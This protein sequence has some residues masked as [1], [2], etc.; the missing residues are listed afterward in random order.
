M[1][2]M[3]SLTGN[4]DWVAK[5]TLATRQTQP[6]ARAAASRTSD[7]LG[8]RKDAECQRTTL[9][10]RFSPLLEAR[11]TRRRFAHAPSPTIANRHRATGAMPRD[12]QPSAPSFI[13]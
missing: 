4:A 10:W 3:V 11:M 8:H 5:N 2:T 6:R 7:S 12:H 1:A 13:T 9:K